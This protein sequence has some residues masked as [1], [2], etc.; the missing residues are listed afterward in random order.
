MHRDCYD[1]K[2]KRLF[3]GNDKV[4]EAD[5]K[6]IVDPPPCFGVLLGLLVHKFIGSDKLMDKQTQ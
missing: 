5:H 3:F 1:C 2:F 6:F 4:F